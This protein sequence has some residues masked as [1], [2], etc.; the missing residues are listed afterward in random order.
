MSTISINTHQ[1]ELL[2]DIFSEKYAKGSGITT[3]PEGGEIPFEFDET[4]EFDIIRQSL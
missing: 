4:T 2:L 1:Y 3:L